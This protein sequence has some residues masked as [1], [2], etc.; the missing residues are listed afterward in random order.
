MQ[1]GCQE[2]DSP[3]LHKK[4]SD[5]QLAAGA[6]SAASGTGSST[7]RSSSRSRAF[8]SSAHLLE[9]PH[10]RRD[11]LQDEAVV[12]RDMVRLDDFGSLRQQ[13]VQR[14]VDAARVSQPQKREDASSPAAP[15]RRPPGSPRS[16]RPPRAGAPVRPPRCSTCGPTGPARR[17][18]AGRRAGAR[19]GWRSSTASVPNVKSV[20]IPRIL[21]RKS[22]AHRPNAVRC[23]FNRIRLPNLVVMTNRPRTTPHSPLRPRPSAISRRNSS[24][25]PTLPM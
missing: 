13:L 18:T 3:R 11:H 12:A 19:R 4:V 15:D 10:R 7:R 2:F 9:V 20:A 25:R 16:R 8:R 22:T 24:S 1:A 5:R 14:G 17:S 21:P 23:L 6:R